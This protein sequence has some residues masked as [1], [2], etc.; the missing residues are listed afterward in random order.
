MS[1]VVFLFLI[2]AAFLVVALVGPYRLYWRSRPRAAGQPSDAAHALGRVAAFGVAGAFGFGG[3]SVLG[4]IDK[5]AWSAGEVRKAA[6]DMAFTL[7]DEPRLPG[8]AA[9]GYAS[10]IEA[11]VGGRGRGPRRGLRGAGRGPARRRGLGGGRR[12]RRLPAR[13]GD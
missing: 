10:L 4:D 1:V 5:G 13:H 8:D 9:E 7:G 6:E 2:A 12:L 11:G 3:C